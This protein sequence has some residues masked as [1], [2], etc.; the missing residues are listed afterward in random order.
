[1]NASA[2]VI[3]WGLII[4]SNIVAGN[5]PTL[6]KHSHVFFMGKL[7]ENGILK[8]YLDETCSKK[9]NPL[10]SYKNQIP[11]HAWDFV[12]DPNGIFQNTGGWDHSDSLYKQVFH[13]IFSS[14][15]LLRKFVWASVKASSQQ[16]ILTGAGDGMG[17]MD[18]SS[19]LVHEL[20][21][22]YPSDYNRLLNSNQQTESINF[23][24][25]NLFYTYTYWI[26]GVLTLILL[27][28]KPQNYSWYIVFI[29][30]LFC[31]S[32]SM[33]TGALANVINRLNARAI[34]LVIP[35]CFYTINET[36]KI[37]QK[38]KRIIP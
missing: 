30:L 10:C 27:L 26:L 31:L 13:D 38:F 11:E 1:M 9:P 17:K 21:S 2:L 5:G 25:F 20:K 22:N 33:V 3:S 16:F 6:G 23:T 32:N 12:W 34:W 18:T 37:N 7:C 19:T 35:L 14:P 36:F 4:G 8:D 28:L 15:K 29:V 24:A